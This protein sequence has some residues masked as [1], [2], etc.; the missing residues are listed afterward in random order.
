MP[1]RDVSSEG[2]LRWFG[3][4][5]SFPIL[6]LSTTQ[7]AGSL[8]A[9]GRPPKYAEGIAAEDSEPRMLRHGRA[10]G[11]DPERVVVLPQWVSLDEHLLESRM[12]VAVELSEW[13]PVTVP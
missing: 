2:S 13:R 6:S 4:C 5:L 9:I 3:S 11:S 7:T 10:G 12:D 8:Q 1:E